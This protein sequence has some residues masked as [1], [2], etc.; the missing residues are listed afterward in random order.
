M[1]EVPYQCQ[2]CKYLSRILVEHDYHV[3]Q[4]HNKMCPKTLSGKHLWIKDIWKIATGETSG[5]ITYTCPYKI[6]ICR[7]CNMIND[8]D[9]K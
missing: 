4:A 5:S 1:N 3:S 8:T 2:E 9:Q 7:A 6:N